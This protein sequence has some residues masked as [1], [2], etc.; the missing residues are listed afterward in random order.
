MK[1]LLYIFLGGG[2][3][4]VLRFL[5]SQYTSKLW[6]INQFPIGTFLVNILGCFLIGIFFS[7][8]AK[9]ESYLKFFLMAGICGGFTTFST[10]SL[11]NFILWQNGSY[12]TLILYSILSVILGVI[13]IFC[14]LHFI[15]D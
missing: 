1:T 3:G 10:F 14:G 5:T 4:S 11:E 2:L 6:I 12:L 8:F 15:K 9:V 7:Y 13:A